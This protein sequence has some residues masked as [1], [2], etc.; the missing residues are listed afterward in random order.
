MIRSVTSTY[1]AI[2]RVSRSAIT[3]GPKGRTGVKTPILGTLRHSPTPPHPPPTPPPTNPPI[4]IN[5]LVPLQHRV[6]APVQDR[7]DVQ[8]EDRLLA[9]GQ[10]RLDH[11]GVQGGQ[12][13]ALMVVRELGGV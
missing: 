12:E 2:R 13:G 10:P 4:R 1:S 8:V 3:A 7:V 5:D 11:L 6:V 9:S